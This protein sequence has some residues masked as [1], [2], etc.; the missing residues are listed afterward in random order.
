MAGRQPAI[1]VI[2][3]AD[4]SIELCEVAREVGCAIAARGAVLICGGLGGVMKAA[5][6]GARRSGSHTIGIIPGYDH[7]SANE[8]V[9]FVVATGMGEARNA[10][11]VAS[12]DAVVALPGEGGTLAEIGFALKLGRPVVALNSWPELKGLARA[13]SPDSAVELALK[14]AAA[15]ARE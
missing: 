9:E 5:A 6:E 7:E 12:S 2:G 13:E 8:H 11:V 10:V 1:A 4:A 15:L 14:L 3:A